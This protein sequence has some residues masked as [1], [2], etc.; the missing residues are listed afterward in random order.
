MNS[1][2]SESTSCASL[3][4]WRRVA[5]TFALTTGFIVMLLAAVAFLATQSL[6]T[7][8]NLYYLLWKAGIRSYEQPIAF[9]GLL[10]DGTYSKRFIGMTV[11]QFQQAF[12][13]TFY[14]V[15]K[16]PPT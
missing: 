16:A 3:R 4:W 10:H 15:L 9:G 14:K 7:H 6:T 1:S 5:I 13:G 12:P 2:S 11:E 8:Y